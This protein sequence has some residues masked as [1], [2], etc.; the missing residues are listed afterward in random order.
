[1][2]DKI[3]KIGPV[4]MLESTAAR[5]YKEDLYIVSYGAVHQIQYSRNA[6]FYGVRLYQKPTKGGVGLARRGRYYALDAKT[7]N[8]V[9]GFFLV[10]QED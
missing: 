3:V 1:M 4:Q 9:V 5:Y 10:K 6:G 8:D 7:V 2:N